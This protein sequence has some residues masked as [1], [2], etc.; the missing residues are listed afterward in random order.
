MRPVKGDIVEGED[1]TKIMGQSYDLV[2][3]GSEI[4]SGSMR[5]HDPE[6]QRKVFGLLGMDDEAMEREFSFFLEALEYGAPPHGGIA[7]GMDRLVSILLGCEIHP[8]RHRLPEEQEVPVIGGRLAG[9]GGAG[10][11]RRAACCS[12]WP[13]KRARKRNDHFLFSISFF[14]ASTTSCELYLP[15]VTF[16]TW[17]MTLLA[18]LGLAGIVL[19]HLRMLV[20]VSRR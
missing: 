2:L 7:L 16:I 20:E 9:E 3:D 18:D 11:A 17:P 1:V 8:R 13:R 15:F 4:G 6:V 10:Q 12:R 5:N 14:T 19:H